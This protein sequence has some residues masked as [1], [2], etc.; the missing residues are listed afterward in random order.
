[1]SRSSPKLNDI[2]RALIGAVRMTLR[3]QVAPAPNSV[4]AIASEFPKTAAW[5]NQTIQLIGKVMVES[6]K[7][8]LNLKTVS[9]H[10]EGRDLTA[11][12][13]LESVRF[14]AVQEYPHLLRHDRQHGRMAMQ[15]TNL[16]DQFHISRLASAPDLPDSVRAIL[17]QLAAH[18]SQPLSEP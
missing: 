5:M 17:E 12:T 3:G 2:V 10:I 7:Q 11:E 9:L 16:N 15:A 13:I 8:N 6:G 14:H 18:L 1:M 4:D